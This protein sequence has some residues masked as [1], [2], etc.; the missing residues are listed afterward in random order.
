MKSE[1]TCDVAIGAKDHDRLMAHLYPGDGDEY[2][3]VLR[4]GIVSRGAGL[5]LL[6]NAVEPARVGTDYVPGKYGYRALAPTFIHRQIVRCRDERMAYLAVHNHGSDR[7]VSFSKVDMD[8]HERGYPALLDIGKGVPVGALVFGRRAVAADIWL[9]DGTRR[10]L[11]SYRVVGRTI[12][13]LYANPRRATAAGAGFDRQ[14]RM[15]GNAGQAVLGASKVAVVGLG[16]V[17]SLVAEYLARLGV[18]HLVL[19]DMDEIEDTNLSRVVGATPTD[20][21]TGQFKTQIAVRHLRE[22]RPDILL[23]A[24]RGDVANDSVAMKLRDCDFIFL[25]ADSMR[26]RLVV[27][28][29]AHQYLIP[30][31]QMGAKIR[32]GAEGALEEAMC[33][34]RQLRPGNGVPVVQ[35]ADRRH[36]AG[37]RGEDGRRTQGPGLRREGTRPERDHP[38]CRGRGPG[39]ERLPVRL[40]RFEAGEW[41]RGVST[42]SFP[43]ACRA[44]RGSA[45]RPELP[46]V[47]VAAGHGRCDRTCRQRRDECSPRSQTSEGQRPGGVLRGC[48][49]R[50]GGGRE[51]SGR[52]CERRRGSTMSDRGTGGSRDGERPWY[53]SLPDGRSWA[54]LWSGYIRCGCRGNLVHGGRMPGLRQGSAERGVGGGAGRRRHRVPRAAGFQRR[55]GKVRGL[56]LAAYAGTGMAEARR[57]GL[58]PIDPGGGPSVRASHRGAW[59]L[60]LFRDAYRETVSGDRRRRCPGR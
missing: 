33:A 16:G 44:E 42:P 37:D 43:A 57:C 52:R 34:V 6:V 50:P 59:V 40:P 14:V 2:G 28:A 54:A 5:R 49:E 36:A 9:P 56:D 18:G 48:E 35:R 7:S 10:A 51:D 58:L 12:R 20:V 30:A 46:G 29:L 47:R 55:R 13:R 31:V 38:Q 53:E 3:A 23:E 11:G 4:A 15:F 41:R 27:N 32:P 1:P 17:G 26:G 24:I 45:Q 60:E 25:A 39:N 19:V 21:E 8:S 22:A